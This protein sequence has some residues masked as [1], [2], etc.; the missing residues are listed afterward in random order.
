MSEPLDPR[1]GVP[2]CSALERLEACPASWAMSQGLPET[3]SDDA[4]K[5][6]KIHKALE[7]G[8]TDGLE[9]DE[10][11]TFERCADQADSLIAE[12][13]SPESSVDLVH[14]REL[15]LGLTTIGGVV[16]VTDKMR[17]PVVVTGQADVVVIEGK[18]G[19]IIDY[20]TGRGDYTHAAGNAQ[21]R[22][23]AAL[24]SLKF[25]LESVRV[26]IVQP[27]RGKPTVADYDAQALS[28]ARAWLYHVLAK[29]RDATPED[30]VAGDHC[31][32]CKAGMAGVCPVFRGEAIQP[33]ERMTVNLNATDKERTKA[34]LFARAMDL[35]AAELV[36][37]YEGLKLVGWY[38]AAIEGAMRK[39][40]EDGAIPGYGMKPG[41]VR[42]TVTAVGA[43][44]ERCSSLGVSAGEFTAACTITKSNLEQ[45]V[46]GATGKKGKALKETMATVLEGAVETKETARRIAKD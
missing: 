46:R 22:G 30:A 16:E 7:L 13:M 18:R 36:E 20:K 37:L 25:K 17:F 45:L 9:G 24:V 26:A 43:V 15:R 31:H 11:E 21:L 19:L 5:G 27:W 4:N 1:R 2:S 3:Q 44:W 38:Q 10:V 39:R 41:V 8:F 35:P 33:V 23:L 12:W 42:E 14:L 6:T 29:V 40:V 32:Y 28:M 34:A